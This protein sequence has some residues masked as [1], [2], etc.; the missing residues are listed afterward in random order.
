M[1]K[2][3]SSSRRFKRGYSQIFD[4]IPLIG[5]ISIIPLLVFLKIVP[6][7]DATAIFTNSNDNYDFFSY[8]K[9]VWLLIFTFLGLLLSFRKHF[10][11]RSQFL[12]KSQIYY[13]MILYVIL[14]IVS[15]IL[16]QYK[17]VALWG[18]VDRYEG[19]F[20]LISY[21]LILFMGFNFVENESQIKYLLIA[22]GISAV[23]IAFIGFTQFVGRDFFMTSIGKS[24]IMPE[25]YKHLAGELSFK[26]ANSKAI[27]ATLYNINYVGVYMSMIFSLSA[28][29]F[30]LLSDKKYKIFFLL[31]TMLSFVTI[32][33][34]RSRAAMFG[35]FFYFLLSVFVF[36]VQLRNRWRSLFIILALIS[37]VLVA[38]NISNEGLITKRFLSG[39][40]SLTVTNESDFSDLILSYNK[41]I[42]VFNEYR[43]TVES[44]EDRLVLRDSLDMP[45]EVVESGNSIRAVTDPYKKH[46]FE[47]IIPGSDPLFIARISTSKGTAGLRIISVK[48]E[49]MVLH[50]DGSYLSDIEAPFLGFE[51]RENIA[52]NRGYIWSRSLPLLKDT[53]LVGHGPDTFAL[54]F[55]H[56]DY[57]GKIKGIGNLNVIVDKP[58]NI[59]LQTAIN[60]GILSLI[61]LLAIWFIYFRDTI[62]IHYKRVEFKKF[63]EIASISIFMAISVY[64]FTGLTND[65]LVSVSPVFWSLLGIGFSTNYLIDK[66]EII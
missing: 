57:V 5:I 14:V 11:S 2:N 26:F 12:K 58:H 25:K 7:T 63:A 66:P 47:I 33:G 30:L 54:H 48:G 6:V 27:Y 59:Y 36:R 44:I 64:L 22:M 39:I 60:T 31:V 20:V 17:Q 43:M 42:F 10:I 62:K 16:A 40:K 18:F 61:S 52:S 37:L 53:I 1:N 13:P 24:L 46:S 65:S 50:Y 34:S 51:G 41:A 19:M 29:M 21:I 8:Y 3:T 15:T 49:F 56:Y 32:L 28:T 9:M 38:V 45:L 55:P 35:I 23:L 4:I